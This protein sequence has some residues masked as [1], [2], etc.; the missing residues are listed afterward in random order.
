MTEF[1]GMYSEP[2]RGAAQPRKTLP[3]RT[4]AGLKEFSKGYRVLVYR[5]MKCSTSSR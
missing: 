4:R 5:F 3:A 1:P 2:I